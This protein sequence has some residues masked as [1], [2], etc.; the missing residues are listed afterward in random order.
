MALAQIAEIERRQLVEKS[1]ALGTALV[2]QL[3][4]LQLSTCN[5]QRFVRGLGLMAGLE[6]R[7]SDNTPATAEAIAA[8]KELL[9]RGYIFL[10]E[11]EH[12][13]VIS[14]TPPLTITEAQLAEAVGELG[15]VLTTD[16]HG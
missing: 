12:A 2:A 10:P 1:A 11:G 5:L 3:E 13:N 4:N 7:R 16:A 14:F 15:K 8:I 6:L 9:K